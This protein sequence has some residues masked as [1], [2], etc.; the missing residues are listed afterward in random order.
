ML[1][2]CYY[3]GPCLHL[4]VT[5]VTDSLHDVPLFLLSLNLNDTKVPVELGDEDALVGGVN[6]P[7]VERFHQLV[8]VSTKQLVGLGLNVVKHQLV[9]VLHELELVEPPVASGAH[10][11]DG[12]CSKTALCQS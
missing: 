9:L 6:G 4:V 8:L 1:A 12:A 10:G 5:K 2:P 3:Q 7:V 11:Q